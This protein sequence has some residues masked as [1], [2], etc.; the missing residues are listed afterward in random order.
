[1]ISVDTRFDP[2]HLWS[3]RRVLRASARN[4]FA[5]SS[6]GRCQRLVKIGVTIFATI[7]S[8]SRTCRRFAF[9]R[10]W[11]GRIGD[12]AR[13]SDVL[14]LSEDTSAIASSAKIP[15]VPQRRS[16]C[17]LGQRQAEMDSLSRWSF[18]VPSRLLPKRC[19]EALSGQASVTSPP[20]RSVGGPCM[21]PWLSDASWT[22]RAID[23][24]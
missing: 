23:R 8:E 2:T 24:A 4:F 18:T 7:S 14:H 16:I 9:Q 5:T 22:L 13:A 17:G 1:M 12:A 10:R 3:F 20:V 21:D 6:L 15:F 19:R 11:R